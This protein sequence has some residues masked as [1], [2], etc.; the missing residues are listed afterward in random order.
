MIARNLLAAAADHGLDSLSTA[1]RGGVIGNGQYV[2]TGE[3]ILVPAAT[4]SVLSFT[5]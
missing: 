5:K 2:A 4:A 1:D 3:Y